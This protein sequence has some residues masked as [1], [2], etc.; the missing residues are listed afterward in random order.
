MSDE[1][2]GLPEA[3]RDFLAKHVPTCQRCEK[4]CFYPERVGVFFGDTTGGH[5]LFRYK[6]RSGEF[7][8]EFLQAAIPH[9]SPTLTGAAFYTGL[10]TSGRTY[11]WPIT[12]ELT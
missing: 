7:A 10:K 5:P 9:S 3:A 6:L 8:C 12:E 2:K 1:F 11:W 4:L